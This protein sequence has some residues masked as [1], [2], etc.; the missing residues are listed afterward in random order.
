MR[1]SL[2][3]GCDVWSSEYI[4]HVRGSNDRSNPGVEQI[5]PSSMQTVS[6][7]AGL[8]ALSTLGVS[9]LNPSVT[10]PKTKR[11]K[12]RAREF[13][14]LSP[15]R[16]GSFAAYSFGG[17]KKSNPIPIC[18]SLFFASMISHFCSRCSSHVV[19]Q[20]HSA[21]PLASLLSI[22]EATMA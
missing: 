16:I 19:L 9:D 20:H 15:F 5:N 22:A 1:G 10:L 11:L 8:L 2:A 12:F 13:N 21:G 17:H 7:E 3:R 4:S 18:S 6:P 14:N